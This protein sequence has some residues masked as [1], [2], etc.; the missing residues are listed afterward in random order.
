MNAFAFAFAKTCLAV[1]YLFAVSPANASELTLFTEEYA[2]LNFE[3]DGQIVGMGTDQVVEM[4]SRAGVAYKMELTRWSRAINLA[5]KNA[6]TCVFSTTHT[7]ER[8]P[9]FQWVEPLNVDRTVLARAK[10][11]GI[12]V[13]D[14]A[15]AAQLRTGTQTGDYTVGVLEENG[16]GNIDLSPTPD[17]TL[18]KLKMG[19]IDLIITSESFLEVAI[20]E[21]HELE[22]VLVLSETVLSLACS[23]ATDPAVVASLQSALQS[24]IDDGTQAEIQAKY[25]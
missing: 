18:K 8:D 11:S 7:E 12:E 13:T 1:A 22:Q 9:N 20:A 5:E 25:N 10:G 23:K 6:D 24:I 17:V 14:V 16:F 2:P 15:A 3:Q 4:M 19:R 21:G